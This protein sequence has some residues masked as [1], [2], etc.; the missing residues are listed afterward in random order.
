VEPTLA[1]YWHSLIRGHRRGLLA[2][3]AKFGLRLA[4]VPYGVGVRTR[5]ALYRSGWKRNYRAAVPV[6]SIGNLSLG[7]T[8]KTPCVEYVGRFYRD[9]EI[10]AAILSRG[11]GSEGGRNDEAMILEEN[12]PDVPHLQAAD[13]V[14]AAQT[15]VEELEAEIAILDDGFQHRRLHRDLDVVLIDA[16]RPAHRDYLFPRGTLRE[17]CAGLR[18]CDA[19]VLTRCNQVSL[20]ELRDIRNWLQRRWPDKSVAETE[21]RPVELIGGE[22]PESLDGLRDRPVAA[23]CGIGN[24]A[25]FR[26]TLEGLG[27]SIV[28]FRTYPDH[29]A[30]TRAD[31]DDLIQWAGGLLPGAAIATTQKDWVKLRLGELAGKPLRVVRI[32]LTFREGQREFDGKLASCIR[33]GEADACSVEDEATSTGLPSEA[34]N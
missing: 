4:S 11:Y 31:V 20:G 9:R 21:H 5:N 7:G 12:L 23:F 34:G 19:I 1:D 30:Y 24:P 33:E 2:H 32:G 8:G 22:V 6:V 25:A 27:A 10:R 13:R 28:D 26:S 3:A 17:P 16:T 18:R 14:F 29:H 15:A